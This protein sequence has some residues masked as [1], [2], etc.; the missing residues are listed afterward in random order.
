MKDKDL[1]QALWKDY[2]DLSD[3]IKILGDGEEN[4]KNVLLEERDKLRQELLK[5]EISR[6]EENSK[7]K[8]IAAEDRREMVR[9][10]ITIITF[11]ISTALSLYAIARTFRFDQES[12]VT[13]TLGRNIL[14][15]VIPK[16]FHK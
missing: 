4:K 13:S 1:E 9:N 8:E 11:S 16:M 14:S 5:L 2:N 15:G 3:I 6:N 7:E 10:R 12:T